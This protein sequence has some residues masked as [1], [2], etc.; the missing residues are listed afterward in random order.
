M[1][2][3]VQDGQR[4][5][6]LLGRCNPYGAE[7]GGPR[8]LLGGLYGPQ[9]AATPGMH[10]PASVEQGEWPCQQPAVIRCRMVC[11]HGHKGQVMQLCSWHD[12]TVYGAEMVAG[13]LRQV[14]RTVRTRGHF[15]EIQRRQSSLCP[16]CAWPP[17]Y[18]ELQKEIQGWQAQLTALWYAQR[19]HGAEAQR[20]R[21]MVDDAGKMMD[22]ARQQGI[23]HNCPLTLV[24]VS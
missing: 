19:W 16:P 12:E 6:L 4:G 8:H 1:S 17:P 10:L 14:T 13:T 18:A 20:L 5:T 7:S 9:S 15:E 11:E 22:A 23:I 21:T 24:P 2:T 3:A